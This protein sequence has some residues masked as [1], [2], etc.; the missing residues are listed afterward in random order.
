MALPAVVWSRLT[1]ERHT[2]AEVVLG[3]ALGSAAGVAMHYL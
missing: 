2:P 3:M 1:L